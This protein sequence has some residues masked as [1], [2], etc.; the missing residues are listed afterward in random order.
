MDE[1]HS[2]LDIPPEQMREMGY[3][4]IDSLVDRH[5]KM[6]DARV[7]T[8]AT[9]AELDARLYDAAPAAGS[10]F[11]AA[12]D[13]LFE[14]VLAV[15]ARVDHPAFMAFV[16]GAPT[17]PAVLGDLVAAGTNTFQGTWLASA[18]ASTLELVVIDWFKDWLH[19]DDAAAGL[20]VSGG[21]AANLTALATARLARADVHP[22]RATLYWST[23]THSSVLRA[24]RTLGF[25][26]SRIHQLPVDAGQRIDTAALRTAIA[27]D[28]AAGLVPL[29]VVANAG[30]TSTGS[31]D[32]MHALADACADVGAWLHVDAAYGGFAALT[33]R[34]AAALQGIERAD[35][36]TLDPHKWLYQPFE[37]GCLIVNDGALLEKAFGIMPPYLQDTALPVHDGTSTAPSGPLPVNFASRG[38][39]LTRAA[40]A[41]K[42][43]LS[44]QTLGLDAFRNAIDRCLDLA[45]WA[46]Q[47]IDAS[48]HLEVVSPARL[49][50]VCF[51]I[52]AER[53]L[54]EKINRAAL[55][56]LMEDG[57]AMIS[58][59]RVD[60][61]FALR[62]CVLNYRTQP[63]DIERV[64]AWFESFTMTP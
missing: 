42:I 9:R 26:D 23:E 63:D 17:W 25:H 39:Q 20:L 62:I 3:R 48:A 64:I 31:I 61:R 43:W 19:C 8:G 30:T 57:R 14:D 35:S 10:D 53:D 4:V 37:V 50:I 47:R 34:G 15:G 46:E 54:A 22:D 1:L 24:A 59:T 16:P 28:R 2:P 40:R 29:A 6:R 21:S 58:S 60:G 38:I 36:I 18:G 55:D 51:R 12:L 45:A 52:R 49:G 33:G 41:F 11:H 32:D 27:R 56:G 7:W 44:I 13:R 5:V